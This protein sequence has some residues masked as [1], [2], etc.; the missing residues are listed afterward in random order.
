[1][2]TPGLL[3]SALMIPDGNVTVPR[4]ICQPARAQ[5]AVMCLSTFFPPRCRLAFLAMIVFCATGPILRAGGSISWSEVEPMVAA[6]PELKRLLDAKFEIESNGTAVR[7]GRAFG[8]LSGRRVGPYEFRM[9]LADDTNRQAD[10]ASWPWL[11]RIQ[12]EWEV[13][14]NEGRPV[15]AGS[16]ADDLRLVEGKPTIMIVAPEAVATVPRQPSSAD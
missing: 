15:E 14:D 16:D 9:R 4:L 5:S 8:N 7:L 11:L 6:V 1:M 13:L 3:I 10:D 12:T 2:A